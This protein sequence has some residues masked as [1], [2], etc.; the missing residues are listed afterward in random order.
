[1]SE[2][3]STKP[4]DIGLPSEVEAEFNDLRPTKKEPI[5]GQSPGSLRTNETEK[6]PQ[7]IRITVIP[8]GMILLGILFGI[9]ILAVALL[10]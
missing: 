8:F 2:E 4:S 6:G 5:Q 10:V 7:A 1:M 9:I 3:E